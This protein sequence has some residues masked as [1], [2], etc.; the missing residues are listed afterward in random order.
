MYRTGSANG[1]GGLCSSAA[2]ATRRRAIALL[3]PVP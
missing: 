2:E 3:Q 1:E